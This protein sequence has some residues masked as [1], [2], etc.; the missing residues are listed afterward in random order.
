M[1]LSIPHYIQSANIQNNVLRYK[2]DDWDLHQY[3]TNIDDDDLGDRIEHLSYRANTALTIACA[4]WVVHRYDMVSDDEEPDQ[5]LE[6]AWAAVVDVAYLFLWEPPDEQWLGPIRGPLSVAMLIVKE[7]I[8]SA[9][10]EEYKMPAL[11]ITSLA[12]HVL[13]DAT[14]FL[15]WRSRTVDRLEKFYIEDPEE[16][17][18]E[19]VPR[20]AMDPDFLFNVNQTEGLINR[21]LFRLD[22]KVNPFLNSPEDM[23]ELHFEGTPYKFDIELDRKNRYEW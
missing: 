20:E 6:A 21:F 5:Y 23:M 14:A 12:K 13:P 16:T 18:G 1:V 11:Y 9:E 3:Y 22:Y 4:E 17:R 19:V 10:L 15:D 2:W 8:M 7:A